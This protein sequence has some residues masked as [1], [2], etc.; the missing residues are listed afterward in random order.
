[1]GE[2]E[3]PEGVDWVTVRTPA[4]EFIFV[5]AT[6]TAEVVAEAVRLT[7]PTARPF[8]GSGAA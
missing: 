8:Q 5:K 7:G 3:L 2:D 4:R 1:V 6:A